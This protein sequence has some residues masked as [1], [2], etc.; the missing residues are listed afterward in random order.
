MEEQRYYVYGTGGYYTEVSAANPQEAAKKA[1][2]EQAWEPVNNDAPGPSLPMDITGAQL[3]DSHTYSDEERAS[4]ARMHALAKELASS[5][6]NRLLAAIADTDV[7]GVDAM[8]ELID[9]LAEI[10]ATA[11]LGLKAKHG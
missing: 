6:T 2:E 5:V 4:E 3:V 7:S 9:Q 8:S 1:L 11:F 10:R